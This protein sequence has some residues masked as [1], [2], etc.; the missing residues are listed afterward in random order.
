M[1]YLF[2]MICVFSLQ[3]CGG[4]ETHEQTQAWQSGSESIDLTVPPNLEDDGFADHKSETD[5]EPVAESTPRVPVYEPSIM[6]PAE[7]PIQ[8]E[9]VFPSYHPRGRGQ[10]INT[11]VEVFPLD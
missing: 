1:R 8:A 11:S 9:P 6:Q 7:T 5:F 10:E 2:L 4:F 3:A